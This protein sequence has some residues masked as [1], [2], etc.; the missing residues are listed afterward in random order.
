M[1]RDFK[2]QFEW[3]LELIWEKRNSEVIPFPYYSA[4]GYGI[5]NAFAEWAF[6]KSTGYLLSGKGG[7]KEA[8]LISPRGE[9]K[10]RVF[11]E[12]E[13]VKIEYL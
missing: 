4:G 8:Y 7:L 1:K 9:R 13:I 6:S 5:Y 3:K 10:R 12:E 11:L 2:Y